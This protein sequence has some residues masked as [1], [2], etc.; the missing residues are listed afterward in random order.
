MT[1]DCGVGIDIAKATLDVASSTAP[2]QPW[3]T[4][5]DEAGWAAVVAYVQPLQPRVIVLEATGGYETGVATALT[6]AGLPVRSSIPDRCAISPARSALSRKPIA[7]TQRCSPRSPRAC[8][9][10]LVPSPMIC[11]PTCTPR[12]PAAAARGDVTAERH[13]LPLARGPCARICSPI[14]PGWRNR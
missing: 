4:T 11:R 12:H 7:S 3:Q 10:P 6:A 1:D 9:R 14:S 5:N 8:S 13:R 2:G